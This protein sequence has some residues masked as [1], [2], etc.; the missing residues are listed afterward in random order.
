ME[1]GRTDSRAAPTIVPAEMVSFRSPRPTHRRR[2]P[3]AS[4]HSPA[5]DAATDRGRWGEGMVAEMMLQRP[6]D[7]RSPGR[8]KREGDRWP[9]SRVRVDGSA[10]VWGGRGGWPGGRLDEERLGEGWLGE[11][12]LGGGCWFGAHFWEWGWGGCGLAEDGAVGGGGCAG[13]EAG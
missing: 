5:R 2:T 6:R 7:G 12:W 4:Q 11:G 10:A 9:H 3:H 13:D 1:A 8:R